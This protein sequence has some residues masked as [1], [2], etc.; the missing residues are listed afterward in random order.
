VS[1]TE[2]W[3]PIVHDA[4]PHGTNPLISKYGGYGGVME[5]EFRALPA[6][7]AAGTRSRPGSPSWRRRWSAPRAATS[8]PA[9]SRTAAERAQQSSGRVAELEGIR[10]QAG[11]IAQAAKGFRRDN[12]ALQARAELSR[13]TDRRGGGLDRILLPGACTRTGTS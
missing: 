11:A 6:V 3:F 12:S 4:M 5:V 2:Y 9:G 13:R 7:I 8:K 10:R 1:T